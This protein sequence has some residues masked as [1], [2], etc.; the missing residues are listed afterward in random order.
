M[1]TYKPQILGETH[2]YTGYI[3]YY[4]RFLLSKFT[5][6]L[7][8]L[9]IYYTP[10]HPH[11]GTLHTQSLT[12]FITKGHSTPNHTYGN[13]GL[14]LIGGSY[15]HRNTN[16]QIFSVNP[17]YVL[18][19]SWY[20]YADVNLSWSRSQNWLLVLAYL[21]ARTLI[22]PFSYLVWQNGVK[23]LWK[24]HLMMFQWM[25]FTYLN[26]EFYHLPSNGSKYQLSILKRRFE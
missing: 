24:Q 11:C 14:L 18:I 4:F 8:I 22:I 7:C 6:F 2:I 20:V 5:R 19:V 26:G 9:E 10:N 3:K 12:L 21:A 23:Y 17:L 15:L 25:I 13:N 16:T 1:C